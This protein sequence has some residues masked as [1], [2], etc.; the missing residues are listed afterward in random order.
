MAIVDRLLA[1]PDTRYYLGKTQRGFEIIQRSMRTRL[2]DQE[3][4][5]Q[6]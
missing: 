1:H 6:V 2:M 3:D 5:T 4:H